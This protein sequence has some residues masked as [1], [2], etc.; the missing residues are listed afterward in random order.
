MRSYI[1]AALVLAAA[2]AAPQSRPSAIVSILS[3]GHGYFDLGLRGN[4]NVTTPNL[5]QLF[6]HGINLNH[7][8]R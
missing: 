4:I 8:Y 2:A 5:N 1:C 6:S 3:D 7:H